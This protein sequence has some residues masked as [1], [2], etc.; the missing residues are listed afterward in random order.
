MHYQTKRK[1]GKY[2]GT[3]LALV[4]L[5]YTAFELKDVA[6][7]PN[8]VIDYPRNGARVSAGLIS[9]K[10]TVR[11]VSD[12]EINGSKL[13]TDLQGRFT[14]DILL[15]DGYNVIEVRAQD[16]FGRQVEKKIEL[17]AQDSAHGNPVA[18]SANN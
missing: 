16:K 17:V 11:R 10:G 4:I 15:S 3:L 13:F 1:V 14:K 8:L 5:G 18:L 12:L 2:V 6:S 7:G 9:V